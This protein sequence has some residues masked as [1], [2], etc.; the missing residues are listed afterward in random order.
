[1]ITAVMMV[2]DEA[3][4]IEGTIRHLLGEVDHVIVA[5]NGST[6]GTLDILYWLPMEVVEDR[7]QAYYQS[8]KMTALAQMAADQGAEWIVPV[9]RR[10]T[11]VCGRPA[12]ER[13][14]SISRPAGTLSKV[15]LWNHFPSGIDPPGDPF[16]SIV[17]RQKEPAGM[18]KVAFRWEEG[19]VIHQ[20]N[21]D[22]TLGEKNYGLPVSL[23]HFPYR[24]AEQFVRKA[25]NGAAAYK[26]SDLPESWGAHWR[27]YGE[28]L[29]RHGP[30]ALEEVF[31]TYFHF[32]SPIDN[33]MV[34]D[35]AP[36]RRWESDSQV[37]PEVVSSA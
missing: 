5:D 34:H 18:G 33:G 30:E 1:M 9:R 21:H 17:W 23:R 25:R 13:S 10:R 15:T 4:I 14:W 12:S 29:E 3:D 32:M 2:K 16:Q 36:Y 24:S 35:P 20:G 28:I 22:V 37:L 31:Y 6:D 7:E 11:L 19:A 27:S 8:E 26:A